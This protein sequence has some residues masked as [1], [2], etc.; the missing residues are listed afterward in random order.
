MA[1]FADTSQQ[2]EGS[3]PLK[4]FFDQHN[5]LDIDWYNKLLEQDIDYDDLIKGSEADLRNLL[6]E[7]CGLK[8]KAVLRII[9]TLREIPESTIYK[10]ANVKISIISAEESAAISKIKSESTRINE[11]ILNV[12]NTMESLNTN[13]K[14]CESKINDNCDVIIKAVNDRRNILL[15]KLKSITD[16]KNNKLLKQQN[17]LIDKAN[18]IDAFYNKTQN[19]TKDASIDPGKR[20]IKILSETKQ[21]LNNQNNNDLELI[22]ND[23]IKI[24]MDLSNIVNDI[25]NIGDV[26][27]RY[28]ALPP[29]VELRDV[30][31][32]QV[33]VLI[34]NN[35]EEKGCVAHKL[36]Y[37]RDVVDDEKLD[38]S[39]VEIE[40]NNNKQE[41]EYI[42][43][44]LRQFT[45]YVV[46]VASR[47]DDVWGKYSKLMPF[48]TTKVLGNIFGND[49]N[50]HSS[51]DSPFDSISNND[52][53]DYW[54]D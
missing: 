34:K 10:T 9:N 44:G 23:E 4:Q 25:S 16:T 49:N 39:T 36:Q 24:K 12:T 15:C 40:N 7:D 46:R 13:S 48:R 54:T 30:K 51:M 27:D 50:D 47:Y 20:K 6:K 22:T 3:N 1:S 41:V 14:I 26:V 43:F 38:W 33:V 52:D 53:D 32:N 42:I 17:I 28:G 37:K 29:V 2:A 19:M 45:E 21:V 5:K 31:S 8:S 11:V 35:D 18:Q